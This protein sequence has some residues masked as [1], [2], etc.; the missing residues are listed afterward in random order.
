MEG[1]IE[2]K[3]PHWTPSRATDGFPSKACRSTFSAP[4]SH[5]SNVS[6]SHKHSTSHKWMKNVECS[7]ICLSLRK[8]V[9]CWLRIALCGGCCR[10]QALRNLR[11]ACQ[12]WRPP[13]L[14]ECLPYWVGPRVQHPTRHLTGHFTDESFQ[15]IN[16]AGTDY[17]I[18]TNNAQKNTK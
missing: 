3:K 13:R 1:G 6:M 4:E 14:N 5:D 10:C 15:A 11:V 8:N 2:K 18:R 9:H 16:C 12:K 17:Q 7:Q